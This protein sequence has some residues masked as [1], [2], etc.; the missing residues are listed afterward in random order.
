MLYF[1]EY[2]GEPIVFDTHGYRYN[3]SEGNEFVIL[4]AN[5]GTIV[6]P[7]YFLKQDVTFVELK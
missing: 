1:G 7:D 2:N 4:R 3:D 5:V 6:L